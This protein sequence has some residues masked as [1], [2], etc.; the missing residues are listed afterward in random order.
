MNRRKLVVKSLLIV[1]LFVPFLVEGIPLFAESQIKVAITVPERDGIE[2]RKE[3]DVKGTA[4][5]PSGN[6]L[7][8]LVHRIKGF[9]RVWWPQNEADIDTVSKKWEV[10]VVFGGPQDVGY[11][12]EIAA[13]VVNE[14][15]HLQLLDYWQKAMKSGD[16]RPIL[17][18]PTVTA[19]TKRRVK[20]SGN[21]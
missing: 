10:H 9:K 1:S 19:P 8:I 17:M 15:E 2:V 13:I 14:Q 5:I 21:Y 6:Y 20:K 18:P 11:D 3:M 12:F 4:S 16:W 7:W